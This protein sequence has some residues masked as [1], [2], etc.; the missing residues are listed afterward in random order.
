M[1][2][3][4]PCPGRAARRA[5]AGLAF[6]VLL[7]PLAA[8]GADWPQWRGPSGQ[9]MCDEKDLPLTWDAK[10]GQNVLWASPLPKGDNPFSSP[11]VWKDRVFVTTALNNP[12]EHHVTCYQASDGKQLWDATVPPGPWILTDLRG[13]YGA[14]TPATDGERVYALF[15][16]AVVVALDLDG[17][18]VWRHDL[19]RYTFDVALGTSPILHGDALILLCDQLN[20]NSS[21]LALDRK[22]GKVLWEKMRPDTGFAHT[23]PLLVARGGKPL[24]LVGAS[25]ALQG[26]DPASGEILWWANT[27]GDVTTPVCASGIAY[28]DSGRG[29]PGIAV[30]PSGQGDVGKTHVKWRVAQIPEGLSSPVLVGDHLY[31]LHN[32]NVLKCFALSTGAVAYAERLEGVTGWASPVATAD[33]RLYFASGGKSVVVKA[34]PAFEVL[35]TGDL[36][37]PNHASPAVADGRLYLKGRQRLFCIGRK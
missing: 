34:G 6:A 10:T 37:D 30:D 13:G 26:I 2:S 11:V 32:P 1:K 20:R 22:T 16:S 24:M 33:G 17:K 5:A 18:P 31:R 14:S 27:P 19:A 3:H 28:S 9:G 35:G 29:G 25:G 4:A 21:L 15:G 12:L 23:T 8:H 7:S 36:G